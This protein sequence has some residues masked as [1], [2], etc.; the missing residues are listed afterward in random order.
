MDMAEGRDGGAGG[1]GDRQ[2]LGQAACCA[3][4]Q[5]TVH[6]MNKTS[7][8]TY[9]KEESGPPVSVEGYLQSLDPVVQH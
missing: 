2:G 9:R 8:T 1:R 7:C 6:L 4:R 3:N 5:V